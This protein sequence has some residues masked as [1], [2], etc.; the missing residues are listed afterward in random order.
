MG[1]ATGRDAGRRGDRRAA[2]RDTI[3]VGLGLFPIG[4]AFGVLVVQS[5]FAWWW[6][7]LFSVLV[8]AGSMEFLMVGLI[9][10]ATPLASIAATTFLVNSRH[11]FYALSFPRHRVDGRLGRAYATYALTDEAYALTATLPEPELTSTRILAIQVLCQAY[12]VTGGIVGALSGRALP[13][14]IRGFGFALVALFAVLA[15]DA[16]R[17][18]RDVPTPLL[19]VGCALAAA[20]IAHERMLVVALGL[21]VVVLLVRHRT[22]GPGAPPGDVVPDA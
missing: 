11:L 20:R 12:W 13:E 5:G 15:L 10:A 17:A 3:G 7:P 16:I 21:L 14:S 6:T 1:R 2:V 18:A 9:S 8:Y 19:A 4:M 22:R